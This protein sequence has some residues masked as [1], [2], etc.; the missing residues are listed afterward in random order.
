[1][2]SIRDRLRPKKYLSQNFLINPHFQKKIVEACALNPDD[3]ILEI[4]PGMGALT[5][6][7]SPCVKKVFAVEKDKHLAEKLEKEYAHSNV[8]IIQAD[9]CKYPLKLLPAP[10]KVIGN[11]PYHISTPIVT[12]MIEAR[13]Q[14]RWLYMTV[15]LEYGK[16]L[17]A[18][19]HNKDYGALSCF[20]QYYTNTKLLFKIPPTAFH[21]APKVQ[22]CFVECLMRDTPR[23]KTQD[24]ELLFKI[25]R[26][27]FQQ[28]RKKI[29][30]SLASW[31]EKGE[32]EKIFNQC[33]ISEN[34]RAENLSLQ[35][36]AQLSNT[37]VAGRPSL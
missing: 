3:L 27:S 23:V 28:R 21:P 29:L 2:K 37:I 7:I 17:A 6:L 13:Q 11:L 14:C 4:G 9:I 32:L 15:Q 1:M 36:F 22:S 34:A 10:L 25:I 35:Q 26:L 20:V 5:S 16:R 30:N 33:G 24:E 8:Q 19:P 31:K 18:E 12:K